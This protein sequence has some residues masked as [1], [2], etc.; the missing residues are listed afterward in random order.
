[1]QDPS[2]LHLT[3]GVRVRLSLRSDQKPPFFQVS[4]AHIGSIYWVSPSPKRTSL[5][6]SSIN[7][8]ATSL[9]A[10]LAVV[11]RAGKGLYTEPTVVPIA[12]CSVIDPLASSGDDPYFED[13]WED[14]V[15]HRGSAWQRLRLYGSMSWQAAI[16][17]VFNLRERARLY[18][19][20]T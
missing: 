5:G 7:S 16:S 8:G 1:M 4:L 13:P 20:R 18:L 11:S 6:N 19:G 12:V 2:H 17:V 3:I 10:M 14:S 15:G 9:S